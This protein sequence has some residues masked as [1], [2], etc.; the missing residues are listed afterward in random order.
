MNKKFMYIVELSDNEQ[1]QIKEDIKK[2]LQDIPCI[3]LNDE[4]ENGMSR[5]LVDLEDTININKYL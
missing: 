3:N 5:K 4:I 2:A 1:K